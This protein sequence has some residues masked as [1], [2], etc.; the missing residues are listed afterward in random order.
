MAIHY[1][2]ISDVK[3]STDPKDV[4]ITHALGSCV[5]VVAYDPVARIGGLIH[6]LLPRPGR[7]EGVDNVSKFVTTGVP[8]MV[9]SLIAAG[10]D[11]SRLLFYGAGGS[12]MLEQDTFYTGVRNMETL[13]AML[14]ANKLELA[15][16]D[17]GGEKMPRTMYLHLRTGRVAVRCKGVMTILC[18]YRVCTDELLE[19]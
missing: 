2:G 17:F 1:V 19:E 9:R 15:A 12:H 18:P 13:Q 5:G 7:N 8:S 11:R 14:D 16:S 4:I 6:C 10:A 3:I